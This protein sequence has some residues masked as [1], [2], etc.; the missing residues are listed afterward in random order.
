MGGS[1]GDGLERRQEDLVTAKEP[2]QI[3]MLTP[4]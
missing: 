1:P 4:E 3:L 2:G